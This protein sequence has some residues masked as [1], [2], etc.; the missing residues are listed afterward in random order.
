MM[1][2]ISPAE[3]HS[4][5][6]ISQGS[7]RGWPARSGGPM[8]KEAPDGAAKLPPDGAGEPPPDGAM[9]LPPD[10]AGERPG[11][12]VRS[13][14][15]PALSS[16]LGAVALQ[17]GPGAVTKLRFPFAV[18]TGL[19]QTA[20]EAV[21]LAHIEDHALVAQGFLQS[22]V[23]RSDIGPLLEG[24]PIDVPGKQGPQLVRQALPG[25]AVGQEP[26]A[27]PHVVGHR[28]VFLH[29]VEL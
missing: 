26:E 27:I 11:D 7:A 9:A 14:F 24:R 3:A 15:P 25:T 5:G 29:L 2:S 1:T 4:K 22:R 19:A 13:C 23:Q 20:A 16:Q 8:G 6:T 12:M 21:G 18:E 17:D 10:G 28:A